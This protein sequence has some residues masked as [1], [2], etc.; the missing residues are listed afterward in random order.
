MLTVVSAGYKRHTQ[1]FQSNGV[2]SAYL[3]RLQVEGRCQADVND[4]LY[5]LGPGDLLLCLPGDRYRLR[6][7][8]RADEAAPVCDYYLN[9]EADAWLTNWWGPLRHCRK[10]SIAIDEQL[11][12]IW[13]AI[14]SEKRRVGD[15]SPAILDGLS[16]CL[17][18]GVQRQLREMPDGNRYERNVAYR[19]QRFIEQHAATSFRLRDAAQAVS[20]GVSRASDIFRQE[21]GQSIMD[22]AIDVRLSMA[23]DQMTESGLTLGQ[24]AEACGF[25]NYTHFNRQF[26]ARFG[27]TPSEYRRSLRQ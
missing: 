15:S 18:L 25:A 27:L 3:I 21:V 4:V 11:L 22:Y 24:V 9:M 13:K 20:L 23:K 5:E 17:L 2:R 1:P 8:H 16:R 26:R 14:I 12:A 10:S 19:I 6:V 7:L